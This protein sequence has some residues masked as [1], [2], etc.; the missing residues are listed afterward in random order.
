MTAMT[1]PQPLK[2]WLAE[3]PYTLAMSS[4]FF[5]FFAHAGVLCALLES[6]HAPVAVRGASAGALVTGLWAAGVTPDRLVAELTGL[7]RQDF[8]DPR[9]G[10]GLLRGRLFDA[11][12][13]GLA[14][15]ARLESC[16]V[17]VHVSVFDV[18]GR[19]TESRTRG[20]L[21]LALRASCAVPFLFH[22][23]WIDGRPKA[24][25]G[26]ADRPGLHG[27]PAGERTL[28][29]HLLPNSPWRKKNGRHATAPALAGLRSHVVQGLPKVTPFRLT[30]GEKAFRIALEATRAELL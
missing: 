17:P 1:K 28:Y 30:E 11:K 7:R 5:G 20:D 23:V 27:R 14:P 24:D 12:L 25:G 16:A 26:I 18:P 21:A 13:R 4:G 19:R 2:A 22:P 29:H 3:G 10:P 8:W 9:P 15:D 6:G